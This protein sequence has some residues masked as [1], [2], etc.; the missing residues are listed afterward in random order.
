[1][2][3]HGSPTAG[4]PEVEAQL[5]E[6]S[7]EISKGQR[8]DRHENTKK[9]KS[10]SGS[11]RAVSN[12]TP[13]Q[14]ARKRA[15]DREAQRAIRE[16]TKNQIEGLERQITELQNQ[17]SH[18]ELRNVVQ[19]KEAI[20][21]ELAEIKS[22]LTHV[23]SIL[24]PIVKQNPRV[25]DQSPP[26]NQSESIQPQRQVDAFPPLTSEATHSAY[27]TIHN[28]PSPLS[29]V[30]EPGNQRQWPIEGNIH[31]NLRSWSPDKS[32]EHPP[33]TQH[34]SLDHHQSGE[35]LG[36]KFLLDEQQQ[37]VPAQRDDA[38]TASIPRSNS[39]ERRFENSSPSAYT[40][41]SRTVKATCPLDSILLDF[42]ASRQRRAAE[43]VSSS[44]LVGPQFPK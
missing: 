39:S 37:K 33:V 8:V 29:S 13:D 44:E 19:Q 4:V 12:L 21:A 7:T 30:P 25:Q 15:N 32:L 27:S 5:A 36:I 18:R 35:R 10:A 2:S 1:M 17:D 24:Q 31:P 42:L 22:Q 28:T 3:A 38:S 20:E 34:S 11:G 16:R 14:L 41:L 23:L 6:G 26:K 43:G 40:T 9:R